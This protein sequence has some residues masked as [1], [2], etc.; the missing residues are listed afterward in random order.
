MLGV[1]IQNGC[2]IPSFFLEKCK[3]EAE[4]TKE[5]LQN[6]AAAQQ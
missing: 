2:V 6:E 3:K 5:I 1:L 4:H